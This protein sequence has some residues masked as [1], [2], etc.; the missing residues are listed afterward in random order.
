MRICRVKTGSGPAFE[1]RE[2][3]VMSRSRFA[4][5][6]VSPF[7]AGLRQPE[8]DVVLD[9]AS[10]RD[11]S[12]KALVTAEGDLADSLFLLVSGRA[13]YFF[14][15]EQGKK[16]IL[17]WIV[18][19]EILGGMALLFE[20]MP[21]VVSSET[22]RR[23]S[24]L[25]WE[26]STI[27]SL[28]A[29]YPRLLDNALLFASQY[30]LLY[31]IAYAA[32]IFDRAH[33]RL[34]NVLAD[35]AKCFGHPDGE[36]V[37]LDVTNEELASAATVTPFTASRLLG[38]WQRKGLVSKKRG[39]LVIASLAEFV[40][41]STGQIDSGGAPQASPQEM[42]KAAKAIGA[43]G[44]FDHMSWGVAFNRTP[45]APVERPQKPAKYRS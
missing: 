15:S 16:V 10:C 36:H 19:G 13:R 18:P 38:E 5:H 33:E 4:A 14:L 44:W 6:L 30:L 28:T 23:S 39:R 37:E 43:N 20:P 42:K 7:F 35:L 9:A 1:V 26:R 29:R 40:S 45:D 3:A 34:A 41:Q 11:F 25:I 21:Y 22:V 24:M 32:V 27:R 12:A 17:H 8:L 2:E 31:R